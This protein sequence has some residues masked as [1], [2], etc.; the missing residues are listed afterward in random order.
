MAKKLPNKKKRLKESEKKE[1]DAK[2]VSQ[3]SEDEG[4]KHESEDSHES[5]D[6]GHHEDEH[7]SED[8]GEDG[9]GAGADGDHDDADKDVALIKKMLGEYLGDGAKGLSKEES[10]ALHSLAKEA[11]HAHKEMGHKEDEAYQKAGDAVALAHHMGKKKKESENE[12][13][14]DEDTPPPKKGKKPAPKADVGDD[15][16]DDGNSSESEDEGKHESEDEG[17]KHESE[18][19]GK[20]ESNKRLRTLKDKL[21]EAEGRIALLEAKTRKVEVDGYA[22]KKL[23]ESKQ[24]SSITK[25]F[26]E[27]AGPFV[28]KK[29]FDSKWKVFLEGVNNAGSK[30]DWGL[31]IE[32]ATTTEDGDRGAIGKGYDFSGCVE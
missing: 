22:D 27:A 17:E 18:D 15:D 25:R 4:E 29:D 10:E 28:S 3:E 31:M 20:K 11:M 6:E 1:H 26:R 14:G 32:K 13:E 8:E 2:K 23:K 24:P 30:V 12:D 9:E 16:D 19:E 7:E 21:L 5:E